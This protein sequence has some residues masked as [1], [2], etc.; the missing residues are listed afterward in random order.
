MQK[1]IYRRFKG[2]IFLNFEGSC[3]E[4]NKPIDTMG[5]E[6]SLQ[7]WGTQRTRKSRVRWATQ[8]CE[9]QSHHEHH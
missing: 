3:V 9:G 6:G 2:T 1:V 5:W 7:A 8:N 4:E